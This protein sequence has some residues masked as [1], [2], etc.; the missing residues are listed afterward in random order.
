MFPSVG[1]A[2][3]RARSG[4]ERPYQYEK[5]ATG[6]TLRCRP[7]VDLLVLDPAGTLATGTIYLPDNPGDGDKLI[8]ATSQAVTALTVSAAGATVTGAPNALVAG[9]RVE[10]R[11]V[12]PAGKWFGLVTVVAN[13]VTILQKTAAQSVANSTWTVVTWDTTAYQD[14]VG[15]FS[16][17]AP[18]RITVPTG[19]TR[20]RMS[21]QVMWSNS[22]AWTAYSQVNCSRAVAPG[23]TGN[24]AV[25][26]I[27]GNNEH[28][29]HWITPWMAG[30]VA[31]DFFQ[32]QVL[33]T[34]G[35]ALNFS[36]AAGFNQAWMQAEWA[37]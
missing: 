12:G 14:D 11:F 22:G 1:P 25:D 18:T 8:V 37:A 20:A 33:Q 13:K 15:G 34:S 6:F 32:Q 26:I 2:P 16:S 9:G 21:G 3:G 35:G 31:G 29:F 19:Y 23:P 5:P 27:T 10:F 36:P 4:S 17:G 30:L 28:G 24:V 7:G